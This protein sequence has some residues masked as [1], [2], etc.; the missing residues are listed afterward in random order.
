MS[1]ILALLLAMLAAQ[2]DSPA[3]PPPDE[4]AHDKAEAAARLEFMKHSVA[5][6]E[7]TRGEKR[8]ALE[9]IPEPVLRW[10]NP[11][12]N[13]PDGALFV[14]LGPDERPQVAAQVFIAAGTKDLWLQEFS[15]LSV[16]SLRLT[17]AG[18]VRWQPQKPGIEFK[19]V[20][21]VQP[22]AGSAVRRLVQM[23]NIAG[24]FKAGDDFEGKSRWELRLL[25]KPLY[26]YGRESSDVLD[27]ALFTFAHGTDP[28]LLIMVEARRSQEQDEK[29]EWHYGLAPMTAYALKVT[30]KGDDVWSSPYRK[31][32]FPTSDPFINVVYRP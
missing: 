30:L 19:K 12:S 7:I 9:L 4:K 21:D 1:P 17:R 5:D 31:S 27:G 2:N 13:I 10:T 24:E 25:A 20:A 23:R 16:E 14:W 18:A 11:V 28:E 15:S 22:P 3:A 8:V 32:P 26:R 6:C 29:Y